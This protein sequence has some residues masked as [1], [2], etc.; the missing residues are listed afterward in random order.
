M[1]F[2]TL[3][4]AL[5]AGLPATVVVDRPVIQQIL[6]KHGFPEGTVPPYP[7][8][9]PYPYPYPHPYPNPHPYTCP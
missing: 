7:Y 3:G 4:P 6:V 1:R 9:N 2:D 8:L 5:E